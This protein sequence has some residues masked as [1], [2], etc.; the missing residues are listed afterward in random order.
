[1]DL[2]IQI[3]NYNTKQYLKDLLL[4]LQRDLA[5][6]S[7]KYKVAVLDNNSKDNLG[8]LESQFRIVSFYRSRK[9]LGYGGG[10]NYLAKKIP[11][12]YRLFLNPDIRLIEPNTVE[13]LLESLK[14]STIVGPCLIN[15]SGKVQL[16]DHGEIRFDRLSMYYSW[17]KRDRVTTVAWVAGT[18]LLIKDPTF[19]K[20]GGFDENFFLY[21]ED[22]DLCLRVR[23]LGEKVTYQPSIKVKHFGSVV[24]GR[25]HYIRPS[26][27]YF[28]DKHYKGKRGYLIFKLIN[29]I[30]PY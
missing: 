27:D 24:A 6:S 15:R 5:K 18:F 25:K 3:I 29:K 4:D 16:W 19:Q 28:L 22:D 9:N 8:D 13:R 12:K 14:D 7:L 10:Q 2:S 26:I 11:A 20:L 23:E 21:K 17:K 30:F 1:M